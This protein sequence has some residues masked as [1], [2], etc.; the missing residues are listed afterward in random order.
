LFGVAKNP[1]LTPDIMEKIFKNNL[2]IT[3]LL[4]QLIIHQNINEKLFKTVTNHLENRWTQTSKNTF[5][6]TISSAKS[7]DIA[8]RPFLSKYIIENGNARARKQLAVRGDIHA[9][10][11]DILSNDISD[12]VKSAVAGNLNT[13]IN[14]LQ[15]LK[16]DTNHAVSSTAENTLKSKV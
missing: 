6:D 9:E 13:P 4:E 1:K 15:K 10:I 16:N 11:L 3:P 5:L 12:E 8:K 2:T 7:L 14:T